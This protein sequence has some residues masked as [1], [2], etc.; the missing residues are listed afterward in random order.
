[1]GGG[2]AAPTGV[3]TAATVAAAVTAEAEARWPRPERRK[4]SR[5]MAVALALAVAVAVALAVA[6]AVF[7]CDDHAEAGPARSIPAAAA[8]KGGRR[9]RGGRTMLCR[10]IADMGGRGEGI[11]TSLRQHIETSP[12]TSTYYYYELLK[13]YRAFILFTLM[14][15]RWGIRNETVR[16]YLFSALTTAY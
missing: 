3:G 4:S 11:R 15:R 9:R 10:G 13:V 12:A 8:A 1:M 6:V 7:V 16:M 14:P 2:S 5:L